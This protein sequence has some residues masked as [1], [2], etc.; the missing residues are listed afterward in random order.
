MISIIITSYKANDWL[1]LLMD[2]YYKTKSRDSEVI[3]VDNANTI[4]REDVSI[5][6]MNNEE[7]GHSTGLDAGIKAATGRYVLVMDADAHFLCK[8]WEDA[9][10][11]ELGKKK[12]VMV[13]AQDGLLKP[14]APCL[15]FFEKQY[16]TSND[17]SF[18][19]V[20]LPHMCI[21][22]GQY[23][24]MR[25]LHDGNLISPLTIQG[26]RYPDTWGN[27]HYLNGKAMFYH[28]WYGSRFHDTTVVDGR[29]KDDFLKSKDKLFK[30]YEAQSRL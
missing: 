27:T 9:L 13:A 12:T 25:T 5:I 2:S 1:D 11:E 8:G 3:V 26:N 30:M 23:F 21:D 29:Q 18:R 28:H 22:V 20:R 14:F 15:M 24:I 17:H 16:F 6:R 19:S 10:I 7:G 4:T